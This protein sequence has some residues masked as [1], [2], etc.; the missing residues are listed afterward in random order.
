LLQRYARQTHSDYCAGCTGICESAVGN[1][2]PIGDVMRYLMYCRDYG[3]R[4]YAVAQ[5]NTIP[6]NIRLQMADV[7]YSPAEKRCP[8]QMAIGRL[9]RAAVA[10]LS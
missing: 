9:M 5:F 7:D 1:G 4:D 10:E 6:D 3:D 8:R 2:V